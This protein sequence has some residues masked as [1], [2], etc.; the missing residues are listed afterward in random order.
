MSNLSYDKLPRV[1]CER[2]NL[3]FNRYT[4][5]RAR[6]IWQPG[7]L[8]IVILYLYSFWQWCMAH[9][10]IHFICTRARR[11]R[12]QLP[13]AERRGVDG[14]RQASLASTRPVSRPCHHSLACRALWLITP[15][16]ARRSSHFSAEVA[17]LKTLPVHD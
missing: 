16:T 11:P 12:E 17:L 15:V 6:V 3:A 13:S 8:F 14:S 9:A 5:V 1:M 10:V 4:C 7:A 2:S